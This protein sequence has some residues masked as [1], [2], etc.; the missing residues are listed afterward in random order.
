[1][2][3]EHVFNTLKQ[4]EDVKMQI[5]IDLTPIVKRLDEIEAKIEALSGIETRNELLSAKEAAAMLDISLSS[6]VNV[7]SDITDRLTWR[8]IC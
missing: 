3:F 8:H 1:M 2:Y 6:Q 5:T 4:F 7:E